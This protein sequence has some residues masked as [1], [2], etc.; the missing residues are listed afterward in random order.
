LPPFSIRVEALGVEI[1][2]FSFDDAETVA[3]LWH[4]TRR[5]GLS[6]ADRA[7]LA[8]GR[9]L[10]ILAHTADRGWRKVDV[11]VAVVLIR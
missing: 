10:G 2:E 8:L 1:E 5:A 9:R 11:G 6:L 7:C 3:E 4:P